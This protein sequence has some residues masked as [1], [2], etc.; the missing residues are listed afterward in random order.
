MRMK[1]SGLKVIVTGSTG[2][3]GEGILHVCLQNP[4]IDKVLI[5]NRRSLGISHRK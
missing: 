5:I 3:V 1:T 2:M 4:N